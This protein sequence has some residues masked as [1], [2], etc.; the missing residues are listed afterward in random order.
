MDILR[1]TILIIAFSGFHAMYGQPLKSVNIHRMGVPHGNYSGIT[2]LDDSLYAIVSDKDK[3]YAFRLL[4]VDIDRE[5]GKIRSC[6]WSSPAER[7]DIS[8]RDPEGIA[9]N[10]H[11]D[12]FFI[13]GEGDQRIAEYSRD[14]LPT[15]HELGVPQLFGTDNIQ[16]NRG[17]E[18]LTYDTTS[19]TYWTTTEAP[20]K[21]DTGFLRLQKFGSD[22]GAQEQY[23]YPTDSPHI[24]KR[25]KLFVNGV[26][27]MVAMGDGSLIIMEREALITKRYLGSYVTIRLYRVRPTVAD[28]VLSKELVTSFTTHLRIGRMNFA[29]F[30][31]I[32]L[33]PRLNDGRQT[34]LLISDSGGGTGNAIYRVKDYLKTVS[35]PLTPPKEGRH[36]E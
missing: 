17:F 20:L 3:D 14:G 26:A 9:Y 6:R 32:C 28:E 23:R 21:S 5:T 15:G 30:E 18:A 25:Y 27:G 19:M 36:A 4:Y 24:T 10:P 7:H 13:S 31:G 1:Q 35:L 2:R 33:G 16:A 34:L 12:T 22:L 29:N 8:R 11:T